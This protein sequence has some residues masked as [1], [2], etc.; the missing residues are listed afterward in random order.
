[1]DKKEKSFSFCLSTLSGNKSLF[2]NKKGN[3]LILFLTP[4]INNTL[5]EK[6]FP[7]FKIQ[8]I[9]IINITIVQDVF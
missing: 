6:L 4:L 7:N 9:L 1:V 2:Y 5:L 8:L 3:I